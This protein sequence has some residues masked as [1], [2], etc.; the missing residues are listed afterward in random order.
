MIGRAELALWAG[1]VY[2]RNRVADDGGDRLHFFQPLDARLRL[3][4]LT[5]L[6]FIARDKV[7]EFAALILLF[8]EQ[9]HI[10][11]VLFS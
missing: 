8:A 3:F 9:S 6:G 1:Q 5:R 4:G 7:F 2:G 10:Q 11:A